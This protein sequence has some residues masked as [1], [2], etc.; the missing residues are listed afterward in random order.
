MV[1]G[2]VGPVAADEPTAAPS[3]LE[4]SMADLVVLPPVG[5]GAGDPDATPWLLALAADPPAARQARLLVL[6]RT[7]AWDA[8]DTTD[9]DVE[10]DEYSARWLVQLGSRRFAL[11]ATTPTSQPG[12]GGGVVVGFEVRDDD[13]HASI[14]EVGR[15]HIDRAIED[16]GAADVDGFG[17]VELAMGLRPAFDTS[18][19]CGTTPLRILD[20][21][22]FGIRRSIDIPGRLGKGAIGRWDDALGDDLLVYASPDCP[23]GGTGRTRLSVIRLL[24]GRQSVAR[25]LGPDIDV[26]AYPPPV[27]LRLDVSTRDLALVGLTD[28][29]Q[30]IDAMAG[31]LATVADDP[32]IPLVA[33][34]EPD[35]EGPADRI[36]WMDVHG[37]HTERLR[38]SKGRL[39]ATGQA[40]FDAAGLAVGRWTLLQTAIEADMR[41]H[42][43]SSAWLGDVVDPRCQD[44]ILPGAILP[45]GEA[46]LRAGAAWLATRPIDTV[47]IQGRRAMLVAAGLGWGP[48]PEFPTAPSPS[49]GAP[50]GWWRHGPSTP[51]AVSEVRANDVVYF[52]DFPVPSATIETAA[53]R[54]GSTALPGFT[55]TRMFVTASRPWRRTRTGRTSRPNLV[56]GLLQDR[57]G[58]PW[59]GPC[60]CRS[61]LATNPGRDGSYATLRL[62]DISQGGRAYD[63]TVVA[64]R[65][66]DQR[67]GR[68][69]LAGRADDLAR[70][71]R[72]DGR[73]WSA[74]H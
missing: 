14:E 68:M 36:A 35:A 27:R 12:T 16:A 58:P 42:G 70:C 73:T 66:A 37:L 1:L 34:A 71:G 20:S 52:R 22:T 43:L 53:A 26:S 46:D 74:L 6:E 56:D 13:G 63:D 18:G 72:P 69:R 39:A 17:D 57:R 24:D 41:G 44:L 19:S 8:I 40:S 11:I 64:P 4:A 65:R 7:T 51:F 9:V 30:V 3:Q 5:P 54:D 55:G 15:T 33:G 60:G 10:S 25:D 62:G 59:S 50:D 2:I 61:R 28:T 67:L 38:V 29:V 23:P 31:S 45:C 47:P 32:G 48:G 21:A 49:A